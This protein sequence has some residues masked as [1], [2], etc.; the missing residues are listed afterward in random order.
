[1]MTIADYSY[2]TN[3]L[4]ILVSLVQADMEQGDTKETLQIFDVG[5]GYYSH[6]LL[7]SGI[8]L[9]ILSCQRQL[10][11]KW[12]LGYTP[13]FTKFEFEN[14]FLFYIISTQRSY[15]YKKLDTNSC[16]AKLNTP[17]IIQYKMINLLSLLLEDFL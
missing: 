12:K 9:I 15:I 13:W 14:S 2:L 16:F 6:H 5:L 1:M 8:T 10:M 4:D 17:C 7:D 3:I 11:T